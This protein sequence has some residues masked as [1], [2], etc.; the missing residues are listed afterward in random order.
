[1][2]AKGTRQALEGWRGDKVQTLETEGEMI[3]RVMGDLMGQKNIVVLNDEAHHCYRE[4]VNDALGDTEGGED[5]IPPISAEL[6]DSYLTSHGIDPVL[7]RADRFTDFMADRENRL[8][9][10]IASATGHAVARTAS[11]SEEGQ[12]VP[13]DDEGFD[14]ADPNAEEVA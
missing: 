8:L 14:L 3:Q 7:F 10:M 1:M 5:I 11:D 9:A 6:L 12:D 13:Q 4:R 2:I